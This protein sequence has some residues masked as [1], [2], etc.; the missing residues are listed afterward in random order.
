MNHESKRKYFALAGLL[1]ALIL[2]AF[3]LRNFTTTFKLESAMNE[4]LHAQDSLKKSE[5]NRTTEDEMA[6]SADRQLR[7]TRDALDR[8]IREQSAIVQNALSTGMFSFAS[9]FLLLW[10]CLRNALVLPKRQRQYLGTGG[11]LFAILLFGLAVQ[12][13]TDGMIQSNVAGEYQEGIENAQRIFDR[14]FGRTNSRTQQGNV[15]ASGQ[16]MVAPNFQHRNARI[17]AKNQGYLEY[18]F[19]S[20]RSSFIAFCLFLFGVNVLVISAIQF[21]PVRVH[22]RRDSGKLD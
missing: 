14:E 17:A 22:F 10:V 20:N 5:I 6:L 11:I 9:G 18:D 4:N 8:S 13:W 3:G 2:I 7:L 1:L 12:K 19:T 16:V 21:D 15:R